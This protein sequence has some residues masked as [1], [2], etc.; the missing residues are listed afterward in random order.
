MA[1]TTDLA[2]FRPARAPSPT[3]AETASTKPLSPTESI[4]AFRNDR[5]SRRRKH[6]QADRVGQAILSSLLVASSGRLCPDTDYPGSQTL[7]G[8]TAD[9]RTAASDVHTAPKRDQDVLDAKTMMSRV[10]TRATKRS[11]STNRKLSC[12]LQFRQSIIGNQ[13][14]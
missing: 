6:V 4:V 10:S 12:F 11:L 13:E 7:M 1:L 3:L 14:R 2:A 8:K 9:V 5:L